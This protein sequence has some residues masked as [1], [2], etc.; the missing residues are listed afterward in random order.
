MFDFLERESDRRL[1]ERER[2]LDRPRVKRAR[3]WNCGE[4]YGHELDHVP[5]LLGTCPSCLP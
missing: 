3:C 5:T 2:R 4:D 1:A